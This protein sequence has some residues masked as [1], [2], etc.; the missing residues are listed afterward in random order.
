MLEAPIS[1]TFSF[2]WLTLLWL[3]PPGSDSLSVEF[4]THFSKTLVFKI[5]VLYHA[6]FDA[7]TLPDSMH[8]ALIFLLPKQSYFVFNM[9]SG[10]F[11]QLRTQPLTPGIYLLNIK[12]SNDQIGSRVVVTLDASKAFDSVEWQYLWQCLCCFLYKAPQARVIANGWTIS[13]LLYLLV[14]KP[15]AMSLRSNPEICGWCSSSLVEKVDADDRI[16]YLA[17]SG[18]SLLSALHI[19]KQFGRFSGL[20]INWDKSQILPIDIF[21]P[22]VNQDT[23]PLVRVS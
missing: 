4:Y 5:L 21:P 10:R 12:A 7:S 19:I 1:V 22:S 9:R 16:L 3:K 14:V 23:L 2:L 15:L 17:D 20:K 6:I 8:E 18:H 13:T 11:C